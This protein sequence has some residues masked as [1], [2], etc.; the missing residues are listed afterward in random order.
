ML[1][2]NK[3]FPVFTKSALKG[4]V[5]SWAIDS[6]PFTYLFNISYVRIMMSRYVSMTVCGGLT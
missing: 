4:F 5:L 2:V 6:Y 3:L 1:F